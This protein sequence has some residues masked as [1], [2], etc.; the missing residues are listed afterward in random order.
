MKQR[1]MV[2][3][4]GGKLIAAVRAVLNDQAFDVRYV[5]G[6]A[7]ARKTVI[8]SRPDLILIDI[9][10][11]TK[12]VEELL[13]EFGN[14]RSTR[15]SRKIILA[16]SATIEDRALALESGA[17][18]FLS[19]PISTRELSARLRAALRSYEPESP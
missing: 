3:Q 19:K 1:V 18:D 2:V 15:F 12:N 8:E 13:C 7:N 10:S 14:F 4:T 9:I 11:W 6:F 17:D 5:E 16:T